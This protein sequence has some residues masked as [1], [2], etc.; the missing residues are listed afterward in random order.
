MEIAPPPAESRPARRLADRTTSL[1]II[2]PCYCE[3]EGIRHFYDALRKCL[4]DSDGW[5]RAEEGV[6]AFRWDV[7]FVDDGSHDRTLEVLTDLSA[8]HDNITVVALSRNYGHQVAISAGLD[9][10]TGDAVVLMDADLQHPP[11]LIPEMLRRYYAGFDVVSMVREYSPETSSLKRLSS[12]S[13]YWLINLL[14]DTRIPAGCADFVLLSRAAYQAVRLM[15]ERH[16]FLR[17]MISWIGFPRTYIPFTAPARIHGE[18]KYT[19]AKMVRLALTAV[20]SFSAV[21]LRITIR[22]GLVLMLAG[23]L[24]L[25]YIV[26]RYFFI[27]DLVQGWASVIGVMVLLGGMQLLFLGVLGEYVIRIFEEA[28]GRPIYF[29]RQVIRS[30]RTRDDDAELR[31]SVLETDRRSGAVP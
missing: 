7:I 1:S 24:Y 23:A 14:S 20:Y 22:M 17:G 10:A 9:Q 11:S 21:P 5:E 19:L 3:E 16:R 6:P 18:S 13:F 8:D 27:D 4:G 29:A 15:P 31:S 2:V 12:Q 25:A 30:G 26:F 28:K